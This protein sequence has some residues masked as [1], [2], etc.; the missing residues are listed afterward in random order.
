MSIG[1]SERRLLAQG[2]IFGA[3]AFVA[4]VLLVFPILLA[5]GG[6]L[7]AQTRALPLVMAA[8]GYMVLHAWPVLYGFPPAMLALAV[9]PAGLLTAVGYVTARRTAA[10]ETPGRYRGAAVVVGYLPVT[11]IAFAYVLVRP[12]LSAAG[13]DGAVTTLATLDPGFVVASVGYTGILF[14]VIFGGLGGF[15]AERRD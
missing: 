6:L 12:R 4:G 14:P 10:L 3:L 7:G 5:A 15:V 11:A 13:G 9:V 2:G 8:F 1:P